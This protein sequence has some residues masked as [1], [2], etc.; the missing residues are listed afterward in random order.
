[1]KRKRLRKKSKTPSTR[2]RP[3]TLGTLATSG[4][5]PCS[6]PLCTQAPQCARTPPPPTP[7]PPAPS[8]WHGRT[9]ALPAQTPAR[10]RPGSGGARRSYPRSAPPGPQALARQWATAARAVKARAAPRV[11]VD[12]ARLQCTCGSV[13][14]AYRKQWGGRMAMGPPQPQSQ[15]ALVALFGRDG[16]RRQR[17]RHTV[18]A[19][20]RRQRRLV[21][22]LSARLPQ[23]GR[24]ERPRGSGHSHAAPQ[25]RTAGHRGGRGL[26]PGTVPCG[27]GRQPASNAMGRLRRHLPRLS[28]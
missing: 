2:A 3:H 7:R 10:P 19:R 8:R 13:R 6:R 22:L 15:E 16:G 5:N 27:P 17:K 14:A 25:K 28:H 11:V 23:V 1:M 26:H 4:V 9:A 18:K 12:R 20:Q 24:P 21:R